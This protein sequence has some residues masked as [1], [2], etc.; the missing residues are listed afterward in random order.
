LK[1]D[2]EAVAQFFSDSDPPI[3][4]VCSKDIHIVRYGFGDA[5]GTGFGSTVETDEGISYR[6]GAWST[7]DEDELSKFKEL[8]NVVASITHAAKKGNLSKSLLYFFTDNTTVEA[9]L[10]KVNSRSRL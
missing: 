1:D 3:M 4:T 8:E 2:L 10:H 7:D 5:S 9:A 6:I